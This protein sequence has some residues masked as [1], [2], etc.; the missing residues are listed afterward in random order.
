M[1]MCSPKFFYEHDCLA[2]YI[3]YAYIMR[4]C[5]QCGHQAKKNRL[6]QAEFR[7]VECFSEGNADKVAS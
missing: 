1:S 2:W 7:C 3:C 5:H 6:S 4:I